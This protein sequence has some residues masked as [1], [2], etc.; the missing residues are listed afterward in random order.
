MSVPIV[1]FLVKERRATRKNG[2]CP[3]QLASIACS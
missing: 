3:T 2:E 1:E